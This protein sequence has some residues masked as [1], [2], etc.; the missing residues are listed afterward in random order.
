MDDDENFDVVM[1]REGAF[2]PYDEDWKYS[3][4]AKISNNGTYIIEPIR[5]LDS[6]FWSVTLDNEGFFHFAD[7]EINTY[8][9]YS[10]TYSKTSSTGVSLIEDKEVS[11]SHIYFK[12]RKVCIKNDI[13]NNLHL[14]WIDGRDYDIDDIQNNGT[15]EIYYKK[16]D[17]NGN[18]LTP[19]I[20]LTY[21]KSHK[22][23]GSLDNY[24][25]TAID[26]DSEG[27]IHFI[28][29]DCRHYPS[30]YA[31]H[32]SWNLYY[33]KINNEGKVLLNTTQIT[34][35]EID[36]AREQLDIDMNDNVNIVWSDGSCGCCVD[37]TENYDI[38]F[39]QMNRNG[40]ILM[41]KMKISNDNK[42]RSVSPCLCI[43]KY[44]NIHFAWN[45]NRNEGGD[46][47]TWNIYYSQVKRGYRNKYN[48]L[49]IVGNPNNKTSVRNPILFSTD[50]D[51]YM[52]Y[53]VY[54]E[55]PASYHETYIVN[56]RESNELSNSVVTIPPFEIILVILAVAVVFA[57]YKSDVFR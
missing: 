34:E 4:Y 52:V 46:Y 16:L 48:N 22:S 26:F 32:A 57:K 31:L 35:S 23:I 13:N 33:M 45:D 30:F 3:Y 9:N 36:V 39:T 14:F 37:G 40:T 56:L 11:S 47:M 1:K 17:C 24:M 7:I 20:R 12:S 55:W 19:D 6:Y 5:L 2:S 27:N 42:Y 8:M 25:S 38:V 53:E 41:D 28:Y 51:I 10:I 15:G 21:R 43:D 49:R 18:G 44:E 54:H 29:K 50:D